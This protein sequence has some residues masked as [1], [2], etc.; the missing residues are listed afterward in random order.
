MA[1]EEKIRDALDDLR[2]LKQELKEKQREYNKLAD[3]IEGL[4]DDIQRG[5]DSLAD[6]IKEY[7]EDDGELTTTFF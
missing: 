7:L 2:G 5:Q 4:D 1:T 6:L 3:E